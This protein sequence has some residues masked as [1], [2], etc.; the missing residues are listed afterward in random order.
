MSELI[1]QINRKAKKEH[2]AY[3]WNIK[4]ITTDNGTQTQQLI[5]DM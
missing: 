1:Q 2:H 4:D 3:F 5:Q